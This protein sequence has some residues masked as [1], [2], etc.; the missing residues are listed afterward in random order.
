MKRLSALLPLAALFVLGS[1]RDADSNPVAMA[2]AAVGPVNSVF[3]PMPE[4]VLGVNSFGTSVQQ[5]NGPFVILTP[6]DGASEN[7]TSFIF[8]NV[9]EAATVFGWAGES[10]LYYKKAGEAR[11]VVSLPGANETRFSYGIGRTLGGGEVV[12]AVRIYDGTAE[13]ASQQYKMYRYRSSSGWELVAASTDNDSPSAFAPRPIAV[14]ADGSVVWARPVP[15]FK[16]RFWRTDLSSNTIQY[17]LPAGHTDGAQYVSNGNSRATDAVRDDGSMVGY[18]YQGALAHPVLWAPNGSV[19]VLP[20]PGGFNFL[21]ASAINGDYI[22]G[23]MSIGAQTGAVRW[24]WNGS[25]WDFNV[26]AGDRGNSIDQ[27]HV[28]PSGLLVA[29][30]PYSSPPG[31]TYG[32]QSDAVAFRATGDV[33]NYS[34]TYPDASNLVWTG[35]GYTRPTPELSAPSA[36]TTAVG[37]RISVPLRVVHP[38]GGV[39]FPIAWEVRWALG[40]SAQKLEGTAYGN[41]PISPV[42]HIY[43]EAGVYTV[44][45][46][47]VDD[48]GDADT[49]MTTVTVY[50]SDAKPTALVDALSSVAEGDDIVLNAAISSDP[51]SLPL[52]YTWQFDGTGAPSG[53]I[54]R[55]KN[56]P[57]GDHSYR[58]IATNVAGLADTT[59]GQVTVYNV[60]PTGRFVSP[61]A[62]IH[63]GTPFTLTMKGVSEGLGDITSIGFDCGLGSY[64]F[65]TSRSVECAAL[66]DQGTYTVKAKLINQSSGDFNEYTATVTARNKAPVVNITGVLNLGGGEWRLQYNVSDASADLPLTV[67]FQVNGERRGGTQLSPPTTTGVKLRATAGD[68]LTVRARDKE[69]AYG[70]ASFT[71]PF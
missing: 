1:C 4:V 69:G 52:T 11:V 57:S 17:Q 2:P 71:I 33:L 62:P 30:W 40:V 58:L 70:S 25:G 48:A 64:T 35:G 23:T 37:L 21:G 26:F 45:A 10:S 42:R 49:T 51:N 18:S 46:I 36:I 66:P 41:G 39:T 59:V 6:F 50:G 29:T 31:F 19:Q 47:V 32:S 65:G 7:I 55:R 44:R 27:V 53:P 43:D 22:A 54:L 24:H 3:T 28:S 68:M 20:N 9:D 61:L 38:L 16:P 60:A 67:T 5:G 15:P 8:W 34:M 12:I 13:P 56:V 14:T 63:E